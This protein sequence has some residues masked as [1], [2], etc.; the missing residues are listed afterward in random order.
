MQQVSISRHST[1]A[2]VLI[3]AAALIQY[4]RTT[5][6]EVPRANT[7][8]ATIDSQSAE[9]LQFTL[10]VAEAIVDE[11]GTIDIAG[12]EGRIGE[13]GAP[14]LPYYQTHIA[15]PPEADATVTIKS[16]GVTTRKAAV[17]PV[18]SFDIPDEIDRLSITSLEAFDLLYEE[19]AAIYAD[20]QLYPNSLFKVSEPFYMRD[21]RVVELTIFP[22]RY[23]PVT[24]QLEEHLSLEVSVA[25][26]GA[27]MRAAQPVSNT[28][29]A[30]GLGI[31]N[32]AQ[33]AEWR[34][35]PQNLTAANT[36]SV[37]PIGTQT[38]KIEVDA[39]AIYELTHADINA[40]SSSIANS[41][42]STFQMMHQGNSI[43]FEFVDANNN[44]QFDSG[45]AIRFYG[46]AF[47]GTRA[48]TLHVGNNV[49]WLW[50]GGTPRTMPTVANNPTSG[51]P[52]T[53]WESTINVE[54][55]NYYFET[56]KHKWET[57]DADPDLWF[58]QQFIDETNDSTTSFEITLPNPTKQG[59]ANFEA[60]IFSFSEN[61]TR[62][63]DV[64]LNENVGGQ[65]TWKGRDLKIVQGT[66]N[67]SEL[68]AETNTI[69]VYGAT[70]NTTTENDILHLNR[71][72]VTYDREFVAVDDQLLFDVDVAGT[73]LITVSGFSNIT[74][75]TIHIYDVTNVLTPTQIT[76]SSSHISGNS[77]IQ[78]GYAN[79]ANA[80]LIAGKAK[81]IP[82]AN[83][84]T[85]TAQTLEP[86]NGNGATWV[87]VAPDV[88]KTTAQTLATHRA[89]HD[90]LTTYVADYEDIINQYGYGLER[91]EALRAYF[92]HGLTWT[93]PLEYVVLAGDATNNPRGRACSK[94]K[95][96]GSACSGKDEA[97]WTTDLSKNFILTDY[98]FVDPEVGAIPTDFTL[99]LLDGAVDDMAAD[100]M[101]G[102]LPADDVTQLG[103]I[104][105]K[106][107]QYDNNLK[108]A[109]PYMS[110]MLW[111]AD[112]ADN[113][114]N[115]CSDVTSIS[116]NV[117]PS[118]LFN[119]D[120]YCLDQYA[121]VSDMRVDF[122]PALKGSTNVASII[123]YRGHG[124]IQQWGDEG[125]MDYTDIGRWDNN[126][127]PA[128]L[129]SADCLDGYF[130]SMGQEAIS[131]TFLGLEKGGTAAHWS[132][133]GLGTNTNHT[134]LQTAFYRGL[135]QENL[136]TIGAAIQ[137][138]KESFPDSNSSKKAEV[139]EF[140]L[141]GDPAMRMAQTSSQ[142]SVVTLSD[143]SAEYDADT[144]E[145]TLSWTS[146]SE[147]DTSSYYIVRSTN[148]S[149][150]E[151]AVETSTLASWPASLEFIELRVDGETVSRVS[152]TGS[153]T[154][155]ATYTA[156]DTG[157]ESGFAPAS[158]Y[159][160]L[161]VERK[162][163]ER[164]IP[165][166]DP[167]SWIKSA[168][169]ADLDQKIYIPIVIR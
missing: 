16:N 105:N 144:S 50:A 76:I 52:L 139:Y 120:I 17:P 71:I 83:L 113:A 82:S 69:R 14:K 130:T 116:E 95:G 56:R 136:Q 31:L 132:S 11:A 73:H 159:Y 66:I 85:Y 94:A 65:R 126:L 169:T 74:A 78:L 36:A 161:L 44:S 33:S 117:I 123:N 34:S 40:K 77:A 58:W 57:A 10:N 110:N 9:Q 127:H 138:A 5:A 153:A 61:N 19:N 97:S 18:P 7:T 154:S 165:I 90:G 148:R 80:K 103:Y 141:Q 102:R 156:F 124:S 108:N 70:T 86:N 109:A 13:T 54:E 79:A 47:D 122:F 28:S 167:T 99:G 43:P 147:L 20:D 2:L 72:G 35:F 92:R 157:P 135:Y 111:I 155:G 115:F 150:L 101:L 8:I 114:G 146:Q 107:Q 142:S 87:I 4:S 134:I 49:F 131:E 24:Q 48:D 96:S 88:F 3:I 143:F 32:V 67:A 93:N 26:S 59:T 37:F 158:I 68:N 30:F 64:Y 89:S 106:I 63:L 160:Y 53:S 84:S 151:S 119:H 60:E 46:W 75:E 125:I 29:G 104:I 42:P 152:A 137:Y 118:R 1:L 38:L 27:N 22:V 51:S 129:I 55:D 41:D 166:N 149:E 23:N 6:T 145:T 39:D 128:V 168:F 45:D 91:P 162:V 25:F 121:S 15:L 140:L 81:S 21:R 112:N 163:S 100:I 133:V 98:Q 62:Q 164:M 12:L